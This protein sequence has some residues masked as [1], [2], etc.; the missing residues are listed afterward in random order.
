MHGG[1]AQL[2]GLR[3]QH[4]AH[5]GVGCGHI[6]EPVHQRLEI[7]HGA[8]HQQRY[9]LAGA[10][11]IDQLLRVAHELGRAVGLQRIDDVDEVMRDGGQLCRRG[12][13]RADVH[14]FV[15]QGR[16][17]A[18]DLGLLPALCQALGQCQRCRSL[19]RGSGAGNGD[20]GQGVGSSHG[21]NPYRSKHKNQ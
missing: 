10:D 14:A 7:Q 16:I 15:D 1:P 13:G 5:V 6:V 4:G 11:F 8:A 12:L 20:T 3:V 21:R 19:A 9:G 18:D 2:G 17:H